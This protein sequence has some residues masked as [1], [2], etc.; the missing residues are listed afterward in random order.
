MSTF[1]KQNYR[2]V[3]HFSPR[4]MWMNDPNGMV[5]FEGEYHLF[6]QH[7]PH[8]M[9]WGPMHW[10]HA[11]SKDLVTWEELDIALAPDEIGMIFSGSIVVDWHNTTGF[12]GE[13]PGLVAIFTHSR[14]AEGA[15][16][17]QTQSLAYSVDK[18]RTWTKFEG[19]P[20]LQDESLIDFRD[21]KVFW[22]QGTR[23]WIMILACG[24]T[25]RLYHSPDLK[26]WTF[27][28][29][30]GD[31]IGFHDGVWECPDLFPLS[32]G[33]D[34]SRQ[35]W[36]MLVSIGD[37]PDYPEGSR[38]QYFTGDFDGLTFTPD[39]E[40]SEIRWLDHG[41]DNYAG[42]SW[43]DVPEEDGRRL[44]I[45]WMSNWKYANL[46]PTE[47]F[48]GAMTVPRE[49]S[50]EERDGA[51]YLL[52]KPA[53]ELEGARVPAL[54]LQSVSAAEAEKALRSLRLESFELRAVAFADRS[55]AFKVRSGDAG[56]TVVGMNAADREV[57]VDRN[58]SGKHDFHPHFP[59]AHHAKLN[60]AGDKVELR[61]LVDRSSIELFADGGQA[62]IT[63]LI[64]PEG[65]AG[66]I[67]F[68]AED[69]SVVLDVLEVYTLEPSA[70]TR[71]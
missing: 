45:G 29:E 51:V 26:N 16:P 69:D 21:P 54:R 18:G 5:Y 66:G 71:K 10:G 34:P 22:H 27:A 6:F 15:Q 36:V 70:L 44:F 24:Q 1:I 59:G 8:G 50:L 49:L 58:K 28:S 11:V 56:E 41:R 20:V 67:A 12:F 43:S 55:F 40:S 9:T 65:E 42:V 61:I 37:N 4:A 38:T 52:Q 33:G 13:N 32:I 68:V 57:F 7:H 14:E 31:G 39:A 17:V 64:Y 23:R 35:K 25:V 19:N 63:D 47:N 46:T 62:V 30:F 48:R 60:A 53:R 2:G 3:Y